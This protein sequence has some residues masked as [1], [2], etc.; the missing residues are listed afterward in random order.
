MKDIIIYQ[1]SSENNN[2]DNDNDSDKHIVKAKDKETGQILH[3]GPDVVQV[4]QGALDVLAEVAKGDV[5]S[6]GDGHY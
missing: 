2:D 5:I 3:S 6:I 1:Q 4:I